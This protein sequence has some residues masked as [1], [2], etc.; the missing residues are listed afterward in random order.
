MASEALPHRNSSCTGAPTNSSNAKASI[1]S[2]PFPY[3]RRSSTRGAASP[4]HGAAS[5]RRSVCH[6]SQRASHRRRPASRSAPASSGPPACDAIRPSAASSPMS[7]SDG[8]K[9]NSPTSADQPW[10]VRHVAP[11]VDQRAIEAGLRELALRRDD[12][13]EQFLARHVEQMQLQVL[14]ELQARD[15]PLHAAP[16]R[17][18]RLERR[19]V[20]QRAHLLRD[21]GIHRRQI[22]PG[23]RRGVLDDVRRDDVAD[24]RVEPARA[25]AAGGAPGSA[26]LPS[27]RP[28]MSSLVSRRVG[29][30]LTQGLGTGRAGRTAGRGESRRSA[31]TGFR[32]PAPSAAAAGAA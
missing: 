23:L 10:R 19:V 27:R 2:L 20:Q 12:V 8:P 30:R 9:W 32:R 4:I 18:E 21:R 5:L 31:R 7:A 11:A 3:G 24:Q 15:Q 22:R 14:V 16:G 26:G 13:G 28:R 17:F 29:A 25:A 1:G 6:A